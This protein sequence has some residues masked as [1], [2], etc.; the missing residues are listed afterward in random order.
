[1]A[2]LGGIDGLSIRR[3]PAGLCGA[4]GAIGALSAAGEQEYRL[5]EGS[6]AEAPQCFGNAMLR[7]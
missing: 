2:A 5:A 1:V 3:L 6:V 7:R 4:A